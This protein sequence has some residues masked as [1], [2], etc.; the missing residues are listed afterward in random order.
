[1]KKPELLAPAGSFECLEAVIEAGCDAVYLGGKSFSARSFATNFNEE[2]IVKAINYA[3]LYGVKVYVTVNTLIYE[4]ETDEFI[5]Y[6]DFLHQ[7]NVDAVL[8]QDIGML[9]LL[10]EIF[11]NLEIHSSTQMHIHNVESAKLMKNLG[12]KRVVLA[13]ETP[14]E[15]VKEI[16]N[17]GIDVETFIHGALCVSYSGQCLMSSLIG[18]RSGNRGSCVGCCR[19]KYDLK[20]NDKIVEKDKYI[21][22]MRDL[23]TI[24]NIGDLIETNIDS[25]KIEGRTKR[26]EYSYLVTKLYRKAIDNYIN[27]GNVNITDKD[28]KDLLEIFNRTFTKGYILNDFDVINKYKPNHMGIK[29]GTVIYS[30]NKITKIKLIDELNH[31]DGIRFLEDDFGLTLTSMKVNSKITEK[32]K[33]NDIVELKLN[34]KMKINSDVVKTT[35]YLRNQE[36]QTQMKNKTR[37]INLKCECKIL[38]NQNIYLSFSDGINTVSITSDYVVEKSKTSSTNIEDV[39]NRINK[40]GDTIYNITDFDIELDNNAFVPNKI[41]NDLKRELINRMNVKRMYKIEYKK[42]EYKFKKIDFPKEKNINYLVNTEKQYEFI[43]NNK[44]NE[45]ILKEICYNLINDDRKVLKL[46]NVIINHEEKSIQEPILVSELGG[47]N[48]YK[49]FYTD[50]TLNVTNSYSVYF[51]HLMGSKKVTLS[52][53]MNDNQ[54]I[55]LIKAYQNRY[56]TQPNLEILFWGR[57]LMMTLKYKL[58]KENSNDY[59]IDRFKN[60]F[61]ILLENNLT[62]IY[63]CKIR[64]LKDKEKYFNMG[65]NNIRYEILLD[66]DLSILEKV[67]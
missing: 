19:L 14:L 41:I 33:K 44:I 37:K 64:N 7:N 6:I 35:N 16:K 28:K 10:R 42:C 34:K 4:N 21:L 26:P 52:L 53:E 13:R 36:I 31:L 5:K 25:L 29:I 62:K 3:H 50:Y 22:S 60:E 12:V 58:L 49:N 59:L 51:L 1:M 61:P 20:I 65:I 23:N 57:E 11:P 2:E 18:N 54:I 46:D 17:I 67:N 38:I 55:D 66:K 24:E 45:V 56:K 30:D 8:L 32:A 47:V 39:K 15:L 9:H 40:L 63:N 48:K 27:T 43:K